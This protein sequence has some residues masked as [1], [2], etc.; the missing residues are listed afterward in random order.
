MVITTKKR[1]KIAQIS[2][3]WG[4]VPPLKYGGVERIVWFLTTE[5]NKEYDVTLFAPGKSCKEDKFKR[6]SLFLEPQADKGLD[7]NAE[8]AQGLHAILYHLNKFKFD[9]LHAH[10]V[11]P[12]LAVASVGKLPL[13]FTFHSV[14]SL[15][16]KLLSDMSQD[17][18][19][20]VFVSRA[21]RESYPWIKKADV[22]Y[23]G[24]PIKNY[25]FSKEKKDYLAF[26][27]PIRPEKGIVEAIEVATKSKTKILI[28]G[29]IRPEIKDYFEKEIEPRIKNNRYIQFLGEITE[30]ERN[31]MLKYAKAFLFPINWIEPFSTSLLESLVVGTPVIAFNKGSV[32]E[33]I[34]HGKNGLIVET[35]TEMVKAVKEIYLI[36][37]ENCRKTIEEKFNSQRMTADY[38]KLY[39]KYF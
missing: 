12:I 15:P 6:L 38:L 5:L 14:P 39:K 17:S 9:V 16:S 30:S 31:E 35:V 24:L 21:H 37:P 29:R 28:A 19:K 18:V 20:F 32:P 11:D 22:V 8:L 25:P 26:V 2:K 7:R 23:N 33:V 27:G 1:M 34:E 36:K 4:E 13:I 10:S 3:P